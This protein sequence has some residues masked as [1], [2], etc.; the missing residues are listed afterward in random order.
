MSRRARKQLIS[1][2]LGNASIPAWVL[3]GPTGS[4]ALVDADEAN[5][6]FWFNGASYPSLASFLTAI[7]GT[8]SGIQRTIGP[9]VDPSNSELLSN[10]DLSGGTTGWTGV[11][12]GLVSVSGGELVLDGNGGTNPSA[13]TSWTS[14][15]GRAYQATATYRR[16]T[17]ASGSNVV[18][19]PSS[20]LSPAAS[21]MTSN[22]TTSN[23]TNTMV[24]AGESSTSYLALRIPAAGATGTVIGDNFSVKECVPFRGF[25]AGASSG[26][27]D[28][29]TPSAA[30]G[31]KVLFELATS[32]ERSRV[33]LVWDASS[34]LRL[35]VTNAAS[36][37]ANIDMGVVNA[38]TS[39]TV[40]YTAA[41]SR[42]A[43][44]LT[45]TASLTDTAGQMPGL[46]LLYVARSPTGGETYDG[47]ISRWTV[48]ASERLPADMIYLEGDSYPA[49][50]GGVSLTAS[51]ITASS[52]GAFTTA[53]GGSDIAT[54][55]TRVQTNVALTGAIFVLWDGDAN[56]GSDFTSYMASLTSLVSTLKTSKYM[57]I[58]P[59]RRNNKSAGD[60]AVTLQIQQAIAAAYPANYYDA[61]A[62]LAT[63]A[64]G[65][66]DNADVAAG[67]I[68]T[69]LLQ[70]DLTHLLATPMNSLASDLW[71][72]MSGKGW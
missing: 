4:A 8:S 7:G 55:L 34:H 9:Y 51:L 21:A 53:T 63:L 43:A 2:V 31:N 64:N 71:T 68:P 33:R 25:V 52:R 10:G 65:T 23:V 37:V 58:P 49:G 13:S 40:E 54:E 11:N 20:G 56:T 1:G 36:D 46:A 30:S 44:R 50:S 47:T 45:G 17:S 32:G 57:I 29:V 16:G 27:I 28:F 70:G 42:F 38:S 6:R 60:N 12:S 62:Y 61:Q 3:R 39:G 72:V 19:S 67:Y 69:S 14:V 48:F 22:N 66:T 26:R 35:I 15:T 5:G 59:C 41:T 24:Q 18:G